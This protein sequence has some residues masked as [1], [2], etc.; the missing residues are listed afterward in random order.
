MPWHSEGLRRFCEFDASSLD[1]GHDEIEPACRAGRSRR[2]PRAEMDRARR[3]WR[4]ELHDPKCITDSKVDVEPPT[5]AVIKALCT[6]S[7][8]DGG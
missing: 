2:Q 8:R 5:Q 4:R 6:I 7:I 3:A 1:I